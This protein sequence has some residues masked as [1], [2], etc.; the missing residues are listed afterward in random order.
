MLTY[1]E[2]KRAQHKEYRHEYTDEELTTLRK[3]FHEDTV[4][5][6]AKVEALKDEFKLKKG[7]LN[8][9]KTKLKELQSNI[10]FR[11]EVRIAEVKLRMYQDEKRVDYVDAKGTVIYT[12]AMLPNEFVNI[13]DEPDEINEKNLKPILKK[14][15]DLIAKEK[16]NKNGYPILK[17]ASASEINK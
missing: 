12:R 9:E 2:S 11:G 7:S 17:Q 13:F 5:Y 6:E 8:D 16:L 1:T 4:K 15:D 10:V 3:V 14:A